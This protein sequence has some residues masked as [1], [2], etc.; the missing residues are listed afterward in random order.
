MKAPVR[1][2]TRK[3]V[4]ELIEAFE[5]V[6]QAERVDS[7]TSIPAPPSASVSSTLMSASGDVSC[8]GAVTFW[9]EHD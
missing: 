5:R 2:K 6:V 3:R 4:R 7:L 1:L 9:L 8:D